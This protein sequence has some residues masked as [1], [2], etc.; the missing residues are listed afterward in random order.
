MS[1]SSKAG[2][3]ALNVPDYIK[4]RRLIDWVAS[5]A[6]LTKPDQLVW[7]DGLQDEYD[8]LCEQMVQTGTMLV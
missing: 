4:H 5:I 7:C 2:V 3:V 8:R 6:E 1:T